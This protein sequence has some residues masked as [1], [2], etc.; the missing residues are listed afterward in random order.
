MNKKIVDLKS[1]KIE[2]S[3]KED[4]FEIKLDKERNLMLLI[5]I[6][7]NESWP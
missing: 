6:N 3:L 2:K 1:Y 4:G 5:K 7:D